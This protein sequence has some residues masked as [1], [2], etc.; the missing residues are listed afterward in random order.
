[1]KTNLWH[2]VLLF[3][4]CVISVSVSAQSAFDGTWRINPSE[5]TMS[6]KPLIL[7]LKDG[8]YDCS[9][10]NPQIHVKADGQDHSFMSD[11]FDTISVREINPKSIEIVTKK[12]GQIVYNQ[13]DTVSQDG[14]TLTIRREE[15]SPDTEKPV[16]METTAS[17]TGKAASGSNGISGSWQRNKQTASENWL[18]TTYKMDG[19]TLVMSAPTGESY[20]AK[21]DGKD[22]PAKGGFVYN[23]VSL[24]RVDGRTIE[25]TD[26]LNGKVVSIWTMS[27]SPDGKTMK[28]IAMWPS[29]G[30]KDT[31]VAEK[32]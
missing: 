10:C 31:Y 14:N 25:E 13:T 22:Y 29:S 20:T 11:F 21:L 3:C 15:R 23:A 12:N 1:M 24:K 30:R 4:V 19:D 7:S 9:N 28:Q 18:L 32:Q 27:V 17:R 8:V 2:F 26:K 6:G 5:S 16:N